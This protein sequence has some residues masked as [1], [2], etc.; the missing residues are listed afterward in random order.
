M[1]LSEASKTHKKTGAFR[2]DGQGRLLPRGWQACGRAPGA[3]L[4][5]SALC[6]RVAET[7]SPGRSGTGFRD[8]GWGG[9]GGLWHV[10]V[11]PGGACSRPL[12]PGR[13]V[14]APRPRGTPR[15]G[16]CTPS[17]RVREKGALRPGPRGHGLPHGRRR[18]RRPAGSPPRVAR[19][20]AGEPAPPRLAGAPCAGPGAEVTVVHRSPCISFSGFVFREKKSFSCFQL[21]FLLFF[22]FK[23][24]S[25]SSNVR[26]DSRR[27]FER[28]ASCGLGRWGSGQDTRTLP[29]GGPHVAC[30]RGAE[31]GQHHGLGDLRVWGH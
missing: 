31:V 2:E 24:F 11:R 7:P 8:A 21:F 26:A 17:H 30:P 20:G 14:R 25:F 5:A 16:L 19:D 9:P 1:S 22:F 18:P 23:G 15:S 29:A 13:W 6:R 27:A 10:R 3:A 4:G 28:A 12:P